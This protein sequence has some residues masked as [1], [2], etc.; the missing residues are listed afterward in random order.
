MI[1]KFHHKPTGRTVY[2]TAAREGRDPD[3]RAFAGLKQLMQ[4]TGQKYRADDYELVM[5]D[6]TLPGKRNALVGA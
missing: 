3:T 2:A 6:D 4:Q 1:A 5:H